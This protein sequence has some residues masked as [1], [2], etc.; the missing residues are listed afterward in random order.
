MSDHYLRINIEEEIYNNILEDSN[1]EFS[2]EELDAIVEKAK[3]YIS[4]DESF[5]NAFNSCVVD[6]INYVRRRRNK[7]DE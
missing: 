4:G 3:Y 6:A 7:I 5:W 2:P 1:E